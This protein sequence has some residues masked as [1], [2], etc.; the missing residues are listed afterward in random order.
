[1]TPFSGFVLV[2]VLLLIVVLAI[3]VR[4]LWRTATSVSPTAADRRAANLAIYRDQ[5]A[6]LERDRDEGSL[7]E[8]DFVAARSELQRRLL[9]D[10]HDDAIVVRQGGGRKAAFLLLAALPLLSIAGYLVLGRPQAL[11]PANTQ[12][13][14]SAQQIDSMLVQLE[15]KL[16]ANPDD[17]KGWVMLARSYKVLG[18][19]ADAAQAYSHGGALL[20]GDPVLLADYAEVLSQVNGKFDGKPTELLAA[21]LKIDPNEPQALF[22]SGAAASE[23][24]DFAAVADYW[25]R[26]LPQL[27][28]GS[29]EAKSLG[30]AVDKARAIAEGKAVAAAPA[31]ETVSGE[32]TLSGKVA[33][34][35]KPDDVLFVFARAGEGSRMPLAVVRAK[36]ADLPLTFVFD[37]TMALPGGQKISD[38]PAITIEARVAKSGQAQSASGDL[39]GSVSG[40]KPGSQGIKVVIDQVQ[41]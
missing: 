38:L 30:E 29:E 21:A 32:I 27:E 20:E 36:V 17:L 14:M 15:E 31:P 6:E 41:P 13:R 12:P 2:A 26:L 40:I 19:F 11:D 37:D 23:R 10:A 7:A 4:P 39:F 22:L 5:L 34:Q 9:D 3:V 33:A 24:K 25:G 28:A 8:T 18:R 1:M 16:K 35:A